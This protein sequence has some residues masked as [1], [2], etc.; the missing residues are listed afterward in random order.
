MKKCLLPIA[1]LCLVYLLSASPAG[2]EVLSGYGWYLDG[3]TLHITENI[4]DS[5]LASSSSS[6]WTT[7]PFESAGIRSKV[8]NIV[9]EEGVTIIG[10]ML[11]IGMSNLV[12]VSLPTTLQEIHAEAFMDCNSLESLTVPKNVTNLGPYLFRGCGRLTSLTFEGNAPR[13]YGYSQFFSYY[14][15]NLWLSSCP[16]KDVYYDATKNWTASEMQDIAPNAVWHDMNT[17]TS[18][19]C[20]ENATW[21]YSKQKVLKI[22]GTGSL[23]AYGSGNRTPWSA[24]NQEIETVIVREGITEIPSYCFEYMSSLQTVSLPNTLSM[25]ACNAFNDCHSLAVITLPASLTAFGS[26]C[27]FNRCYALR[28]IYYIGTEAEWNQIANVEDCVSND[29]NPDYHFL[30]LH[31][32]KNPTCTEPGYESYYAFD[33]SGNNTVYSVSGKKPIAL[34]MISALDHQWDKPSY[35]WSEDRTQVTARRI[36]LRDGSHTETETVK[37]TF[38]ATKPATYTEKGEGIYTSVPFANQAF[39]VQ[40]K[41]VET[42]TILEA[43]KPEDLVDTDAWGSITWTL[44]SND[45][46]TLIGEGEIADLPSASLSDEAWHKYEENI[47]EV[48]ISAGITG[49]GKNAFRFCTNLR[50]ISFPA[51]LRTIGESAFAGCGELTDFSM[52]ASLVSIGAHAFEGLKAETLTIPGTV[53]DIGD[54]AFCGAYMTNLN[55]EAGVETIGRS[56]FSG[57]LSLTDVSLPDSVTALGPAAFSGCQSLSFVHL[58]EGLTAIESGLFAGCE[59]LSFVDIPMSVTSIGAEAFEGVS[60]EDLWLPGEVT[61]IG[62]AAFRNSSLIGFMLPLSVTQLGAEAFC[63]TRLQSITIPEGITCLPNGLFD[64]CHGLSSI[65]L[66]SGLTQIEDQVFH[67]CDSLN[68]V[69]FEGTQAQWL[70]VIVGAGND[71]LDAAVI[72]FE[73]VEVIFDSNGHGTVPEIQIVRRGGK[74]EA[75][76][77]LVEDGY[78]FAGW[79]LEPACNNAWDFE[80]GTVTDSITLYAAWDTNTYTVTLAANGG[81]VRSGAITAYS[82]GTGAVLPVDV[83]RYGWDFAGWYDNVKLTGEPITDIGPSETGDKK[84]WAKWT[85]T[86]ADTPIIEMEQE[87]ILLDYGYGETTLNVTVKAPSGHTITGYQWY[88]SDTDRLEDGAAIEG[89]ESASYA[90]P[91]EMNTGARKYYYCMVRTT[92]EDNGSTAE[93]ASKLITV[94]VQKKR[95]A[96]T[97]DSVEKV[98]G[99]EDPALTYTYEPLLGDDRITGTLTRAAGEDVGVY[100]IEQGTLT[101]GDHYEIVFTGADLTITKAEAV[102]NVLPAA[103]LLIDNGEEQPLAAAGECDGG[104]IVYWFGGSEEVYTA[105]IPTAKEPGTYDVWYKAQ[106]D[107]NHYDSEARLLVSRII[108]SYGEPDSVLPAELTEIGDEAFEGMAGKV[109]YV[110]DTCALIGKNAFR[111]CISM[112]QIRLPKD[113]EIAE[114]AFD[115]CEKLIAVYA[116]PGGTTEKWAKENNLTFAQYLPAEQKQ[117]EAD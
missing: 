45:L 15:S 41:T 4:R 35:T 110:P 18:G 77:P 90:V 66:P 50:G 29:S 5:G 83:I 93:T 2:A 76:Q 46:L 88:V 48:Y 113:C 68:D 1:L 14:T 87:E 11:F 52:P 40:T 69:Y 12:N 105:E 43:M 99:N 39:S 100:A 34:P 26:G 80:N 73:S 21:A 108:P 17:V 31:E 57:C 101:A 27:N 25:L 71:R 67:N 61:F 3:G 84:F 6:Y 30:T 91:S 81:M 7:S 53:K 64:H 16:I 75:P 54:Y 10:S 72:H 24:Y 42:E 59:N 63:G 74:I 111:N 56:A 95:V 28:D 102:I 8:K 98:Y 33:N 115:G 89:A 13:I 22:Y 38:T 78:T 58:P 94:T 9:V 55:I 104:M 51:G 36:C 62:D 65:S 86:P 85:Q 47:T 112:T 109:I 44:Y 117:P 106:G 114:G 37:T 107:K 97:A 70:N 20:G 96:V 92:R 103:R 23:A 79:Y 82:Y 19:A 32:A 60:I 116:P 49:I